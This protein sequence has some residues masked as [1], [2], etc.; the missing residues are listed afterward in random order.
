V[1]GREIVKWRKEE[2]ESLQEREDSR[3]TNT[4]EVRRRGRSGR[5]LCIGIINRRNEVVGNQEAK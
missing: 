2:V 5:G 1:V 3:G 4:L